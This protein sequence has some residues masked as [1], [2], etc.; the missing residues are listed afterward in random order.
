MTMDDKE[1]YSSPIAAE[2]VGERLWDSTFG[3]R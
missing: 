1:G 2:S 3:Y